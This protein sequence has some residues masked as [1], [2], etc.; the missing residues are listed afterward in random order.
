MAMANFLDG[1]GSV[2]SGKT[3]IN[4]RLCELEKKEREYEEKLMSLISAEAA[5][6]YTVIVGIKFEKEHLSTLK[7]VNQIIKPKIDEKKSI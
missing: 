5:D 6:I 4:D 1:I 3:D 2:L 7:I